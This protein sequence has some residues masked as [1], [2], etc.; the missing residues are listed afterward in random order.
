MKAKILI[1]LVIAGTVLMAC[2]KSNFTSTPQL[3]FKGVNPTVLSPN[4]DIVF[5]L[6]YTDNERDIQNTIY[7]QKIT[8]NCSTSDFAEAYPMPT[9]VPKVGDSQ[10]EID[11]SYSYGPN[12]RYPAIKEPACEGQNDT[13]VFRFALTDLANHTSDT[14]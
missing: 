1:L 3:T 12:L 2:N 9:D 14:I 11:I 6:S 5:Q 8:Q 7:V 13:C 4:G 10:G